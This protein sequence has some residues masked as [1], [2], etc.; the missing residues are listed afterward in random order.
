MLSGAL[1]KAIDRFCIDIDSNSELQ[2]RVEGRLQLVFAGMQPEEE[3]VLES[4]IS[5]K[6]SA[7]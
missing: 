6:G 1:G 3:A 2:Q 7:E 4:I 5:A